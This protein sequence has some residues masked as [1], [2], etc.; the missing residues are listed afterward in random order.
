MKKINTHVSSTQFKNY[1][2][3]NIF[4]S[5]ITEIPPLSLSWLTLSLLMI[6]IPNLIFPLIK[7]LAL[8]YTYI[9]LNN[10]LFNI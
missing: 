9:S 10:I 7:K 1:M 2:V 5:I 4:A 6:T 3:I 8:S